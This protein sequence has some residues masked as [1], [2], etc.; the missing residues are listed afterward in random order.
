MSLLEVEQLN[1]RHG[2]LQA[3]REVSFDVSAGEVVALVG[4]NGAG[5]TTLL[6]SLAGAH[7]AFSGRIRFKAAD[8]TRLP[9]YR[10]CALGLALVPEG[11]RLFASMTVEENLL[12]AQAAA[13]KGYW[14]RDRVLAAFPNLKPRLKAKAGTLSGG[15]QQAT[16]IG[17][18]LMTNPDLL[19][20]DEI[21][22][23]L[24]P[25]AVERV[26]SSLGALID[27]GTTIILVEQGLTRAL[28]IATR[29]ICML[30]GRIA[31]EGPT[32]EL[33]RDDITDAYFGLQ[34]G[35]PQ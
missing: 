35:S 18:A 14:T 1:V 21:S 15:E 17:R 27:S 16:A 3:V 13:R 9:A 10:R 26:Y 2:Q 7:A 31:L 8:I 11:R 4:A 23:G 34:R 12:I 29:V 5:K 32:G 6:R 20:L 24:S 25:L 33:T 22:L 19:I 28:S 30:E